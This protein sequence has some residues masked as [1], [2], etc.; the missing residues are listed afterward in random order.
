MVAESDWPELARGLVQ[1][2]LSAIIPE[3]VIRAGG[4]PIH[5]EMFGIEKGENNAGVEVHRLIMNL[6]PFNSICLSVEGDVGTLPM[7]Q[8][9]NTFQLHPHAE[10][11]VSCEDVRCFFYVFS[12][13]SVW[14][15][16]LTFNRPVPPGLV[17]PGV[18]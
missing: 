16:Y 1:Y 7:L 12:L 10:M 15:P 3:S 9:M 14:L 4:Q 11:V 8:P 5:N 2:N 13:P 6:I 18:D 17:P